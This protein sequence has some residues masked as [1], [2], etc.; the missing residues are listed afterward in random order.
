MSERRSDVAAHGKNPLVLHG[1]MCVGALRCE[2]RSPGRTVPR[3]T[4]SYRAETLRPGG[5][6]FDGRAPVIR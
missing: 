4:T 2:L 5:G 3:I 1:A 6:R